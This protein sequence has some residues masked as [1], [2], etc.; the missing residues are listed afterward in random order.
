MPHKLDVNEVT[1][2]FLERAKTKQKISMA[3][4]HPCS[5]ESL[6]G[7]INAA[8]YGIIEPILIAPLEKLNAIALENKIDISPYEQ[9]DVPHSHGAADKAVQLAREGKVASIM[10]GSLHTDELMSLVV[11]RDNGLRTE[12]RISHI[13]AFLAANYH[14]P[15][16]I[17]DAAVNIAP[18]LLTKKDIVQNAIDFVISISDKKVTP[19]VAVICAVETINPEMKST[20]DAAC[21]CKM[22]QR[23]QITN[24]TLDG[25]LAFDNAIS[26][27]AAKI[28]GIQSSVAGHADIFLMPDIESGNMLAKQLTLL[29]DASSA[30]V[31]LGA[32][33]PIVLTSRSD[34][35]QTRL[36]SCAIAVLMVNAK[37][38]LKV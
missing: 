9:I 10:K 30:G 15:F 16:Y 18:D 5:R 4:V 24:G 28:K 17:T 6:E 38:I 34:D 22:A 12:R 2:H 14:K 36:A 21:L 26:A 3:V 20:I 7:A 13:F 1:R 29:T 23:G 25:P 8:K 19:K 31:V 32:K 27:E 35:A 33:V 37:P 11:K